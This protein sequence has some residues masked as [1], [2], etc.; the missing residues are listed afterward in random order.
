MEQECGSVCSDAS[1]RLGPAIVSDTLIDP[2]LG[3]QYS[4]PYI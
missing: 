1:V 4:R 2:F 3:P